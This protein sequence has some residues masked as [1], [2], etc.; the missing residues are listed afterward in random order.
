MVKNFMQMDNA[1]IH[2]IYD[3]LWSHNSFVDKNT[4]RIEPTSVDSK[5]KSNNSFS[6]SG[7]NKFDVLCDVFEIADRDLF[8]KKFDMACSGSGQELRRIT[9][10]HSSSLCALLF[11]YN[12]TEKNPLN[13]AIDG[14]TFNLTNSYFEYKSPV[15]EHPSN[16]DVVLVGKDEDGHDVV[17][18]I[19]SKFSEYV[20]S[21]GRVLY[22][23]SSD[24]LKTTFY[25]RENLESYGYSVKE[26]SEEKYD[27]RSKEVCYLGG[28]KQ[29]ISHYI[30]IKNVMDGNVYSKID[31][32]KAD[33]EIDKLISQGARVILSEILFDYKI[34]DLNLERDITYRTSYGRIYEKL[35]RQINSENHNDKFHMLNKE[36]L[37]SMFL[38]NDHYVEPA[39]KEF[40]FGI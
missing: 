24:Y 39:I 36:L 32:K 28:F 20:T 7:N 34:G 3:C 5:R 6:F 29:M 38:E 12:I 14:E 26:K 37:Y 15:F 31:K 16:M 10:L 17:L 8:K 30:G 1:V 21:V 23:Q 4:K 2:Q 33:K 25:E 22:D 9:T 13:L 18:F 35:A 11:F 40:Y 19:E 27:L